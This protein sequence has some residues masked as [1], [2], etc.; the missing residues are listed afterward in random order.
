[1]KIKRTWFSTELEITVDEVVDSYA[2]VHPDIPF[3]KYLMKL[4]EKLTN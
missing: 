4:I 2:R 3:L 1:M